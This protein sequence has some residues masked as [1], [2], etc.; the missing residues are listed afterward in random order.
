M[1][2][3]CLKIIPVCEK[4]K[5]LRG[6]EMRNKHSNSSF[7]FFIL[8]GAFSLI[9]LEAYILQEQLAGT[10]IFPEIEYQEWLQEQENPAVTEEN[11]IKKTVNT[12]F[13]LHYESW[14]KETLLDFAF[15]FDLE[16][17]ESYEDYEYERGL[18][19]IALNLWSRYN[20]QL[21]LYEYNPEYLGLRINNEQA[22]VKVDP[23]ANII[24]KNLPDRVWPTP[25]V[26]TELILTRKNDKWLI[27]DIKCNDEPHKMYPRGMD[28]N[29]YI[30]TIKES[31]ED[32]LKGTAME[33]EKDPIR[34]PR[35][36]DAKEYFKKLKIRDEERL[37]LLD[38][39]SGEY[40]FK[41]NGR[42]NI[43]VFF[44]Q[45]QYFMGK[46]KEDKLGIILQCDTENPL[47][48]QFR[49]EP[50]KIFILNFIK[51]DDD[52]S[53]KCILSCEGKKYIGL[54]KQN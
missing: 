5:S 15:L 4:F 6:I 10:A 21:K 51:N 40:T 48:F 53:I 41:I 23:K 16:N 52:N 1:K 8:F 13:I 42:E 33:I 25:F 7:F 12:Y 29:K 49:Y 3:I 46:K 2:A 31:E 14:L 26:F 28:F 54:K 45:D 11:K 9:S 17:K 20:K 36:Q 39:I 24:N 19:Y 30:E 32:K 44:V 34:K 38:S 50:G 27:E 37:Q 43:F 47:V 35:N 18:L 22:E